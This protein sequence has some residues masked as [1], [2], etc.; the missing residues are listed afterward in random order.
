[1][2]VKFETSSKVVGKGFMAFIH[3]IGKQKHISFKK[4]L[5]NLHVRES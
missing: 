3:I 5:K 4:F 1:M 2:F